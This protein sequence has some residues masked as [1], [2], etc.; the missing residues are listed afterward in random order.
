MLTLVSWKSPYGLIVE[1]IVA[2]VLVATWSHCCSTIL[3]P[4]PT[5]SSLAEDPSNRYYWL[6]ITLP[7][8]TFSNFY[9]ISL[10][11]LSI[12]FLISCLCCNSPLRSA[13]IVYTIL[14]T[15]FFQL[16]PSFLVSYPTNSFSHTPVFSSCVQHSLYDHFSSNYLHFFYHSIGP[17][18]P[19]TI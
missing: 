4:F 8:R 2:T 1:L 5:L 11:Y 12:S 13:L 15:K 9:N 16:F 18:A 7:S 14:I 6:G 3:P 17:F 10:F 19:L